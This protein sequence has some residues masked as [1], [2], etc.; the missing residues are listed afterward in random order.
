MRFSLCFVFCFVETPPPPEGTTALD[1]FVYGFTSSSSS[2]GLLL[3]RSITGSRTRPSFV[4]V[5][6]S[7]SITG[8]FVSTFFLNRAKS[9]FN[10]DGEVSRTLREFS[11]RGNYPAARGIYFTAV[12]VLAH[13][14]T[15][16]TKKN[17]TLRLYFARVVS[18]TLQ[19]NLSRCSS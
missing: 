11:T 17:C 15:F 19:N 6:A 4:W 14:Y 7:T 9:A 12:C 1:V 8:D 5:V 13:E 10:F 3:N 16:A 18:S 2:R